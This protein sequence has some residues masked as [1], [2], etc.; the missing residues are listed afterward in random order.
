[1]SSSTLRHA[2]TFEDLRTLER[3]LD[4]AGYPASQTDMDKNRLRD[5]AEFL[6]REFQDGSSSE[7]V[8]LEA[9][10]RKFGSLVGVTNPIAGST[11]GRFKL[12]VVG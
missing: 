8:L 4:R 2:L 5:A 10:N 12:F 1:M 6:I 7:V 9:L 3:V 11:T